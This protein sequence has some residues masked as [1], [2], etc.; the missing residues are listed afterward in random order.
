MHL[1]WNINALGLEHKCTWAGTLNMACAYSANV[2]AVT[3]KRH[4]FV[5]H[6]VLLGA[7]PTRGKV[8]FAPG[9]EAQGRR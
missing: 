4:H 8:P 5:W 6:S 9:D 3:L 7:F 2:P 1:G